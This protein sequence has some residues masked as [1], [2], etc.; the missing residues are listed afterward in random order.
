ME[1]TKT[2]VNQQILEG[3]WNELKGKIRQKWGELSESDLSQFKGNMD[4]L[5]GTIQRKT[6]EGRDAI[7]NYLQ[8]L[9]ESGSSMVSKATETM[10][11]ATESARQYAQNAAGSVQDSAKY[12]SDQLRAGYIGA[13]R[14][15]R[16]RP[17]ESLAICFGIGVMVG[18]VVALAMRS[19]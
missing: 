10:S 8:Q 19:R 13:E 9:T 6:G 4:Q 11:K 2:M 17:A 5:V 12:A 7:E 1:R 15:V 18:V 3:N 16:D 14:M